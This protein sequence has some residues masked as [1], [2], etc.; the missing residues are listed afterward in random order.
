M[1]EGTVPRHKTKSTPRDVTRNICTP[2]EKQPR[3]SQYLLTRKG[4]LQRQ[5]VNTRG[6][7]DTEHV[8]TPNVCLSTV[9]KSI[10]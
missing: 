5:Y 8:H 9:E 1:H 6:A 7:S 4:R 10:T 3:H 2:T